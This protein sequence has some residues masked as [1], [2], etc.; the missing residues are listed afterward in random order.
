MSECFYSGSVFFFPLQLFLYAAQSA[1]TVEYTDC[2]DVVS[3]RS[4]IISVLDMIL[5][6]LMVRLRE[7]GYSFIAIAPWSSLTQNGST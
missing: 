6:Y 2:R 3:V 7:C 1:G 4:F 5:I